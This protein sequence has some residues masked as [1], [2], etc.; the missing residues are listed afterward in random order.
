MSLKHKVPAVPY[1]RP[2]KD[3]TCK[4]SILSALSAL[5]ALFPALHPTDVRRDATNRTG[6]T[7][8]YLMLRVMTGVGAVPKGTMDPVTVP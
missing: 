3:A 7:Y 8:T 5:P 6:Y 2:E 4:V 1:V